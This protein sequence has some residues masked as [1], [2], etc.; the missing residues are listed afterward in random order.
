MLT[1]P[2]SS[3][4]LPRRPAKKRLDKITFRTCPGSDLSVVPVRCL[5]K[6]LDDF[7]VPQDAW[8]AVRC[9]GLPD[10]VMRLSRGS[11]SLKELMRRYGF[12]D[13]TGCVN[14]GDATAH[15]VAETSAFPDGPL[16]VAKHLVDAQGVPQFYPT[17]GVCWFAAFCWTSFSNPQ[18]AALLYEHMPAPMVA[19]CRKCLF[20]RED[21]EQFR[22]MLWYDFSVGDDVD[23]DPSMDGR[24]GFSEFS[25]MCAKMKIPLVRLK[26]SQGKLVPM[27]PRMTDR[28]GRSVRLAAPD[29]SK[30][31]LLAL[32][33]QD[34]DHHHKHP[35][36]RRIVYK[37]RR[38]RLVGLYMGQ[39]KCGHQI[40]VS[41]PTGNWRDWSITDADL[42]K[43]GIGP[44]HIRFD[45]A[46]WRD[47]W[48]DA[49]QELV[50]VTK[51]GMN[52]NEFCNLSPH[53]P[54]NASLDKYKLFKGVG[55]N[56][57]DVVYALAVR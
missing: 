31:H 32:R 40:G 17:S 5:A 37:N 15:F 23:L 8:W 3:G 2:F 14:H 57:I 48:W 30:F 29:T 47:K 28:K 25:V 12:Q 49:W 7:G 50:H 45:G 54:D 10:R 34:G 4:V 19:R 6:E 55:T 38:Y 41:C 22:K 46:E 11:H 1:V 44:I 42:H 9:S 53:N 33:Y 51:F 24:N 18:V 43:D 20:S 52:R 56:S 35:I 16:P 39:Q 26:E 21:A 36:L 13:K 27:D